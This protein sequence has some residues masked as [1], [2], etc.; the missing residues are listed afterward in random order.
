MAIIPNKAQLIIISG[1]KKFQNVLKAAKTNSKYVTFRRE[2]FYEI[3]KELIKPD[4]K[5]L[6]I[7]AGDGGFSEYCKRTDFYLL[8]GNKD[9]IDNLIKKH[10]NSFYGKLPELLFENGFFDV[11]HCSHVIEYLTSEELYL[12]LKEMDRCLID[13]GYIIIS[14][15]LLWE[16]FYGDLSHIKPYYPEIFNKYMGQSNDQVYTREKISQQYLIKRLQYRFGEISIRKSFYNISNNVF[17]NGLFSLLH[18]LGLRRYEKT[19]YTIVLQKS[20][21]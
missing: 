12:T 18:R 20:K 6:D 17:I 13:G 10:P 7:G 21:I 8:D 14:A 16:N 3:A 11:I 5:V 15:P 4:S 9:N 2:P 1:I 19:G